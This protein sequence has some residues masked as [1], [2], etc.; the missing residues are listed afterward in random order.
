MPKAAKVGLRYIAHTGLQWRFIP[1][2]L[3]PS[4]TVYQQTQRWVKAG[5]FEELVH[6]LRLLL[7]QLEGRIG[8]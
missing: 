7:C 6:D 5:I 1:N 3:P 2:D 4:Y 8:S